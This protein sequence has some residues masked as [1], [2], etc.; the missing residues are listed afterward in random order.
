MSAY[1]E[2]RLH[3]LHL[4]L[5]SCGL[6]QWYVSDIMRHARLLAE[7]AEP[8]PLPDLTTRDWAARAMG[9]DA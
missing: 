4:V 2:N 9:G 7:A 5:V 6:E 3:R 1:A 8:A